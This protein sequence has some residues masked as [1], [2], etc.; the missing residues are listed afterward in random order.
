VSLLE[1]G[2]LPTLR[3]SKFDDSGWAQ[4][5]GTADV[6]FRAQGAARAALRPPASPAQRLLSMLR[7]ASLVGGP[8][9]QR[10]TVRSSNATESALDKAVRVST[11]ACI[12]SAGR[13][14]KSSQRA[15]RETSAAEV[16]AREQAYSRPPTPA[17]GPANRQ[18]AAA[19]AA[20]PRGLAWVRGR[21]F[22]RTERA[23]GRQRAASPNAALARRSK[24][25]STCGPATRPALCHKDSQHSTPARVSHARTPIYGNY[26]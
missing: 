24:F 13:V 11:L 20:A 26:S 3:T 4:P 7:V 5:K 10:A 23:T 8:A 12:S 9:L 1:L 14:G 22:R 17:A 15:S 6:G 18:A 16:S 21:P 19:V 25:R 2:T